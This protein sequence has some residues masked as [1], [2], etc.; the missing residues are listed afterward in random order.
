MSAKDNMLTDINAELD[1]EFSTPKTHESIKF[2]EKAYV[3]T[4]AK[5]C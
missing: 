1:K 3:F 5:Y 4:Q 2:D